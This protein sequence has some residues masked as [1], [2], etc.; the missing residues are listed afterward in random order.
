MEEKKFIHDLQNQEFY[1][2]YNTFMLTADTNV[3]NKLASKFF[4][5]SLAR[6]IPG[7]IVELGVFKGSGMAGWLKVGSSMQTSR[8]VIGFDFFNQKDLIDSIKTMDGELMESLFN[9][10]NF[11]PTGYKEILS[12]L[13]TNMHFKNFELHQGDVFDTIPRYLAENPGFRISIVNFDLD[14]EAPT[15][16]SLNQLWPRVVKNGILIFDEYG[17][18]EWT[19]S[20]A[21]DRFI[22][23]KGLELIRTDYSSPSAYIIKK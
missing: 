9:D 14:T 13:L 12:I 17:I 2:S 20:D 18:N 7:D 3:F 19:E 23:E 11:N 1:D 16:F 8:K 10:R 4:F 21:V 6:N 22:S 15:Y 5:L